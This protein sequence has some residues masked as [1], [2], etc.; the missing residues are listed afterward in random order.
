MEE[1]EQPS[2]S[3]AEICEGLIEVDFAKEKLQ[4]SSRRIT[5]ADFYLGRELERTNSHSTGIYGRP[6]C[7]VLKDC[8]QTPWDMKGSKIFIVGQPMVVEGFMLLLN[9]TR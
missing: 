5:S 4:P 3:P 8:P 2:K 7:A 1:N 9:T 6:C